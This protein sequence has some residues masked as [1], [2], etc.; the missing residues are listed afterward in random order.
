LRPS[1]APRSGLPIRPSPSLVAAV[2]DADIILVATWSRAP[3]IHSLMVRAGARITTLGADSREVRGR[4]RSPAPPLFFCDDRA[5]AVEMGAIGGAGLDRASIA[6]ELGDVFAARI[7]G[8]QA[9]R[10]HR[11][12]R[13]RPRLQDLVAAARL[14]GRRGALHE[15]DFLG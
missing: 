10:D 9:R 15:V 7:R 8:C 13:R 3:L 12:R 4:R 6:A 11:L 14:R 2:R 5:L 1:S